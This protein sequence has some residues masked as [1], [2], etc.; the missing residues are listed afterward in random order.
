MSE[1]QILYYIKNESNSEL[2]YLVAVT[3]MERMAAIGKVAG[4]KAVL[5]AG[6]N[7]LFN[8]IKKD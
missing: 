7:I 3:C 8:M 2:L 5:D 6:T 4:V 1:K